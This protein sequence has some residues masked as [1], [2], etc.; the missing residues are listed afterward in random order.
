M[1]TINQINWI[2]GILEGEGC[3]I[4]LDLKYPAIKIGM[5]DLD[6][7]ERVRLIMDKT[8][9]IG[10]NSRKENKSH[11]KDFYHIT[12]YG[13]MAIQWMMTIYPLMSIRRKAKIREIIDIWKNHNLVS[14]FINSPESLGRATLTRKLRNSGFSDEEVKLASNLKRLGLSDDAILVKIE[15]IRMNSETI[16]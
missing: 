9:T 3:F 14:K 6:V 11:W 10:K 8:R 12:V 7:I 13:D 16:N 15:K 1:I 4:T 2:A 5:T